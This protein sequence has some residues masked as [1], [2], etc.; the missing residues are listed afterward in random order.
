MESLK[1]DKYDPTSCSLG[2]LSAIRLMNEDPSVTFENALPRTTSE[3]SAKEFLK[4]VNKTNI[5]K[6]IKAAKEVVKY[7]S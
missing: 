4:Q 5:S 2:V 3:T 7:D 1:T 6:I